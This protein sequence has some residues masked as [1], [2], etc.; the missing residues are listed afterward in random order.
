MFYAVSEK[1][2]GAGDTMERARGADP[3]ETADNARA[4]FYG[5]ILIA[6]EKQIAVYS[7]AWAS[8]KP[9]RAEPICLKILGSRVPNHLK[10]QLENPAEIQRRKNNVGKN[11]QQFCKW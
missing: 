2:N 1:N 9:S 3:T 7:A 5:S 4:V 10:K 11:G 8:R 6:S